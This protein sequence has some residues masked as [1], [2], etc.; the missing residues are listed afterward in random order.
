MLRAVQTRFPGSS[1]NWIVLCWQ[2]GLVGVGTT[3]DLT[4]AT[5]VFP[6]GLHRENIA[7]FYS[8]ASRR[9]REISTLTVDSGSPKIFF[10]VPGT[11]GL[12]DPGPWED[13]LC[14]ILLALKCLPLSRGNMSLL[15]RYVGENQDC[16]PS[17]FDPYSNRFIIGREFPTPYA[18]NSPHRKDLSFR[19][20]RWYLLSRL[21]LSHPQLP[22]FLLF[23][24][25]DLVYLVIHSIT[26]FPCQGAE[27]VN[28]PEQLH[29]GPGTP[30]QKARIILWFCARNV[31]FQ[32]FCSFMHTSDQSNAKRDD[33]LLYSE[34]GSA[35]QIPLLLLYRPEQ[36]WPEGQWRL[37][38]R[39]SRGC[40]PPSPQAPAIIRS[41]GCLLQQS[42]LKQICSGGQTMISLT[43]LI[44]RCLSQ[45]M[46]AVHD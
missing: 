36:A 37:W 10:S 32:A 31:W 12:F 4:D 20:D 1:K 9:Y 11:L 30:L 23:S 29:L 45:R 13:I 22:S 35:D 27:K 44:M 6:T 33:M 5:Y 34:N 7:K 18:L 24:V 43:Q 38:S 3:R 42:I 16:C 14:Q 21:T 46:S 39:Q 15:W 2:D 28:F 26:T 25:A 8:L 17:Y 41:T 19:L 40:Q